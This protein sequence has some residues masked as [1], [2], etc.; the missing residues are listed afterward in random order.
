M[1]KKGNNTLVGQM[2][3]VSSSCSAFLD[4]IM[5]RDTALSSE[6]KQAL[7]S[8]IKE[9]VALT[10]LLKTITESNSEI[11]RKG[12]VIQGMLNHDSEFLDAMNIEILSRN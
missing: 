12:L 8:H 11:V 3:K 2:G 10:K 9:V 5:K 1:I 4:E 6:E 7:E